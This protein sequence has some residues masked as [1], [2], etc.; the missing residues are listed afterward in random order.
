MGCANDFLKEEETIEL[1][2]EGEIC[3]L[4]YIHA[5]CGVESV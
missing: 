3:F 2:H 1:C 5:R 4:M